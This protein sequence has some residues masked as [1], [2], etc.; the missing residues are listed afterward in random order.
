MFCASCKNKNK[1][2]LYI[3]S[4]RGLF[5]LFVVFYIINMI[6]KLCES[7]DGKNFILKIVWCSRKIILTAQR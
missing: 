1:D 5:S 7:G 2:K 6:R 4:G 3:T